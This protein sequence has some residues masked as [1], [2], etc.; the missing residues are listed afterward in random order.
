MTLVVYLEDQNHSRLKSFVDGEDHLTGVR[1]TVI[2]QYCM[3][4]GVMSVGDTMFN[5]VQMARLADEIR[6]V[7]TTATL[8]EGEESALR[9]LLALTEEAKEKF[10]YLYLVGE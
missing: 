7:L 9:Q 4:R 2:E 3:L 5:N 6:M 1:R 10:R 8:T